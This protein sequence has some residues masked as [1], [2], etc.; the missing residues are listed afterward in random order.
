[1]ERAMRRLVGCAALLAAGA[2]SSPDVVP[3]PSERQI[4]DPPKAERPPEGPPRNG[5]D[6][7][8]KNDARKPRDAF[9][10]AH[11]PRGPAPDLDSLFPQ[12]E[13]R[14]PA[15]PQD[16][17]ASRDAK[18]AEAIQDQTTVP[19]FEPVKSRWD[20]VTPPYEVNDID[21]P[22]NPYRRNRLKGDFPI[23]GNDVFLSIT[24]TNRAIA[25]VRNVPTPRGNTGPIGGVNPSFFGDGDQ[26]AFTNYSSL[27]LD[28]FKEPQAFR[29]VDWRLRLTGVYNVETLQTGE[30]GVVNVSPAE[31]KHRT[32][33]DGALQEAFVEVHLADLSHR[34]DFISVEAG[35]LPF[36]S[37]FR[38]FMFEDVNLG[39]RLSANADENKWQFNLAAFN[40]LEK[41]TRSDLNTFHER[42]QTVVIFNVYRQDWPVLGYTVQ[43]SFHWNQDDGGVHFDENGVLVRPAPVGIASEHVVDAYYFG[44]TGDGHFGR[45]NVTNAFYQAFGTDDLNPLA[46][47]AVDINAQFAALEVSYDVDWARFRLFGMYASGD[48]DTTDDDAEGFDAVLDSPNFAG[49][50]FSYWNRQSLRLLG[51]NLDQRLSA[52]PDLSSA[53]FEGQANFVNPGILLLGGAVDAELTPTWRAQLGATWLRFVTTEVLETYL[54]TESIDEAIGF[55]AFLGTQWRPLL[56]NNVVVNFGVAAL[57]PGDGLEKIYQSDDVLWQAFVDLT[58][59]W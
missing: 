13:P 50:E 15:A 39:I 17:A 45:F 46:T 18:I 59:T 51:V 56:T 41:D 33:D 23:L 6:A 52:L 42:D 35:I 55:E 29:P 8:P 44:L 3:P 4:P 11:P 1:M 31:G 25:E 48:D 36:R 49:G 43:G 57:W 53:K 20:I 9:A 34:Y 30:V 2:C 28:L 5:V 58:L 21:D 10:A 19:H 47:R 26:F 7:R 22:W 27:T 12:D 38:G 24:G 16:A 37:D 40:L 14:P 54:E 32:T